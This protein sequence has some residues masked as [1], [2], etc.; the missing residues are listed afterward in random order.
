MN[1]DPKVDARFMEMVQ[2]VC[3]RPAMW[4]GHENFE[5]GC[6]FLDGYASGKADRSL[7]AHAD[8]VFHSGFQN[9][10]V[11]KYGYEAARRRRE[12]DKL[13]IEEARARGEEPEFELEEE[14]IHP[15]YGNI[16]WWTIYGQHFK[17]STDKE[18]FAMLRSDFEDFVNPLTRMAVEVQ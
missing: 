5:K 15:L 3:T 4:V 16:V 9:F 13:E 14:P 12:A 2:H 18:R 8:H 7:A 17:N 11:K 1:S 10:L 6:I